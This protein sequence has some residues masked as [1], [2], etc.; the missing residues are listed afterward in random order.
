MSQQRR[1]KRK[2]DEQQLGLVEDPLAAMA[3]A[4][5]HLADACVIAEQGGD[6]AELVKALH[7]VER[8]VAT[9]ATGV[10][11]WSENYPYRRVQ[12]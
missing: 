12:P 4:R 2:N 1:P 6:G 7:C 5:L 3:M 11:V 8:C 10:L 9:A